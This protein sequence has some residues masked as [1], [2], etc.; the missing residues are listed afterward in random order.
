MLF[1]ANTHGDKERVLQW[2]LFPF[3]KS[4]SA[5]A[6]T[7]FLV[8]INVN[9]VLLTLLFVLTYLTVTNGN[10]TL[11]TVPCLY[12]KDEVAR[13]GLLHLLLHRPIHDTIRFKSRV[14]GTAS[15]KRQ[16]PLLTRILP[17]VAI[18]WNWYMWISQPPKLILFA[19]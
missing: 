15:R 19:K 1:R 17:V 11:L 9:P 14:R 6:D 12:Q 7:H 4:V 8:Y 18:L 13:I 10:S 5:A 3:S 16:N 2:F